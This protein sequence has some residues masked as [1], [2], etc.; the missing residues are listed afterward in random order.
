MFV[1][2]KDFLYLVAVVRP[3]NQSHVK[4]DCSVYEALVPVPLQMPQSSEQQKE[5][6]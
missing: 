1:I 4:V 2:H 3:K 5:Q 6:Q